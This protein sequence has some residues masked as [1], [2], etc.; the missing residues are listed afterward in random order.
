MDLRL[1]EETKTELEKSIIKPQT[2]INEVVNDSE[3]VIEETKT[4]F[5]KITMFLK[6]MIYCQCESSSNCIKPADKK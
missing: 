4:C 1:T 5:T 2:I 3:Q 6:K